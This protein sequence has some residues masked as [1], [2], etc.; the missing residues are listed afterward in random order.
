MTSNGASNQTASDT[1][2]FVSG[3]E[4]RGTLDILWS[5]LSV[6]ILCTWTAQHP[7]MNVSLG[8]KW[9][10]KLFLACLTIFAPDLMLAITFSFFLDVRRAVT[11]YNER[12]EIQG[13]R[14]W[15]MVEGFYVEMEGFTLDGE[16][17][18]TWE[19][20]L[21]LMR[22]GFIA[23][24]RSYAEEIR[25]RSKADSLAKFISVG[26]ALWLVVQCI[27]RAVEHLPIST[28]EFGTIGYVFITCA[29]YVLNWR[30]P[31]DVDT[32]IYIPLLSGK[33]YEAA[34]A[35]LETDQYSELRRPFFQER[36][37]G[38]LVLLVGCGACAG[39]GAWH[40]IAWNSFF[41]SQ[42]EQLLWRISAV[43]SALPSILAFMGGGLHEA[44]YLD[45]DLVRAI[46][47]TLAYL[48]FGLAAVLYIPT[49][50][51]LFVEMFLGLRRMPAGMFD[52]VQWTKF[53]PHI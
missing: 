31:K 24:H 17:P 6:L 40:C 3:P 43:L 10:R 18:L 37:N 8:P 35:A 25:D 11:L 51:F 47:K 22:E 30:K 5:C 29:L 28:L 52:T 14:K 27:A 34:N 15:S 44:E 23:P 12:V 49:R 48:F 45:G 33:S 16:R 32:R 38:G 13:G 9:V 50:G 7:D 19:H 21:I 53:I 1:F 2:G 46:G 4:G 42:L 41:P 36:N 20:I 26:Q 39:F